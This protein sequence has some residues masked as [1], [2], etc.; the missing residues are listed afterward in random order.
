MLAITALF[1]RSKTLTETPRRRSFKYEVLVPYTDPTESCAKSLPADTRHS[2][3]VE[4][5]ATDPLMAAD[6][7]C[8][9]FRE[10]RLRARTARIA[11]GGPVPLRILAAEG[12]V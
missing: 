4:V 9:R 1:L 12:S 6:C 8:E 7:A 5:W 3:I 10:H 2:W 11:A